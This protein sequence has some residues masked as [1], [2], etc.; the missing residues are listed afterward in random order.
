MK[1]EI[2]SVSEAFSKRAIN[3]HVKNKVINNPMTLFPPIVGGLVLG[4]L[5]AAGLPLFSWLAVPG[6]L[7]LLYGAGSLTTDVAWRKDVYRHHYIRKQ[8]QLLESEKE[9][10]LAQ[11]EVDLDELGSD[12][13]VKQLQK[14]HSKVENLREVLEGRLNPAELAYGRYLGIA[15]EVHLAALD[16]LTDIALRLKSVQTIDLEYIKLRL[17]KL[18]SRGESQ[19]KAEII[20][21]T[22]RKDLYERSNNEVSELLRKNEE[23]MTKIDEVANAIARVRT[24]RGKSSMDMEMAMQELEQLAASAERTLSYEN[25][26]GGNT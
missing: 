2:A 18:R 7:L 25:V 22:G 1:K 23:A 26:I 3:D 13:G 24:E 20:T 15:Q 9:R 8:R 5:A 19:D 16:N 4:G 11:L 14:L 12:R 21:L 10:A 6:Y 17:R